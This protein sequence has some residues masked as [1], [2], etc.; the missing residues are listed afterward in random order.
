M[1]TPFLEQTLRWFGPD[2]PASLADIR[3]AGASGVVTALYHVPCGAIWQRSEIQR[4]KALIE[5]AG[6]KWSVVE[7]VPVHEDIKRSR[8]TAGQYLDNYCRTLE[9][10]AAC[11]LK[12]VC[13]NFM[14]VSDWTRTDVAFV[15]PDGSEISRYDALDAAAFDLLVLRR[16]GAEDDYKADVVSA[17]RERWST[18][19]P[20]HRDQISRDILMGLPGTVEDLT[21]EEFRERLREYESIGVAG[22]RETHKVFLRHVLPV[23]EEHG[24]RLAIH[25]DD[26]PFPVFGLPRIAGT[27]ESLR[28]LVESVKSPAN[29]ITFCTG[30]LALN[31]AKELPA[32]L[33]RLGDHVHFLHLRNVSVQP[34]GSFFENDH[35]AGDVDM[36]AVMAEAIE[37][38][39]RRNVS[40]PMRPDHGARMLGDLQT[41]GF[42]PGYSTI[43]RLRGLAELRGLELGLHFRRSG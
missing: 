6:L 32:M 2:D 41:S 34:D 3:Q 42:Y 11:G 35:L 13:Y 19:S 22:L 28:A 20:A 38:M 30:S 25:P 16:P 37:M 9:N 21:A 17:A 24:M 26:P 40:L 14:A 15:R 39:A 33:R 43:G 31:A 18:H 23:A 8:S 36:T 29:G 12:T 7:S 5:A 1:H 10:L 4:R 27:E